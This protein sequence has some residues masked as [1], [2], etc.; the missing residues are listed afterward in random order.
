M[1]TQSHATENQYTSSSRVCPSED[2][3]GVRVRVLCAGGWVTAANAQRGWVTTCAC[4]MTVREKMGK[5]TTIILN[6]NNMDTPL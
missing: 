3:E 5:D 1:T 4:G 2:A 6:N